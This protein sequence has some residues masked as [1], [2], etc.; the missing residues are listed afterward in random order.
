M[1][2]KAQP[3][4]KAW[5]QYTSVITHCLSFTEKSQVDA[6]ATNILPAF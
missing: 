2:E 1:T 6:P 3:A 5:N 4:I